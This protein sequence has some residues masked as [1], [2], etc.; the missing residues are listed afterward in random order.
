[1]S[2]LMRELEPVALQRAAQASEIAGTGEARAGRPS[3]TAFAMRQLRLPTGPLPTRFGGANIMESGPYALG[4]LQ[5]LGGIPT[6]ARTKAEHLIEKEQELRSVHQEQRRRVVAG[7]LHFKA[8]GDD[9][10]FRD[11][12]ELAPGLDVKRM[13]REVEMPLEERVRRL[14][15]KRF[16][17]AL[18]AG[19]Q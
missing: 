3:G 16:R 7:Y 13:I 12:V 5:A 17:S 4:P 1:M 15:P 14:T 10:P 2:P 19:E 11:A 18:Y 9:N 6:T 8:T